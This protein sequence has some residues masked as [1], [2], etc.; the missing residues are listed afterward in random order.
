MDGDTIS[1][2]E[3]R[4]REKSGNHTPEVSGLP[5]EKKFGT[6]EREE[7]E[8]A[9]EGGRRAHTGVAEG[10][11]SEIREAENQPKDQGG[12]VGGFDGEEE[13]KRRHQDAETMGAASDT[14]KVF[15][16]GIPPR[17]EGTEGEREDVEKFV[18]TEKKGGVV[19]TLSHS[20]DSYGPSG[21]ETEDLSGEQKG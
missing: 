18:E 7:Q 10:E 3:N 8:C 19:D 12:G 4:G 15:D 20:A 5:K 17:V 1:Q 14:D 2:G 16:T 11:K 21:A 13:E 9:D 6:G